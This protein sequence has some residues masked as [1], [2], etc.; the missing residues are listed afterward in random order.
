MREVSKTTR[1][2]VREKTLYIMRLLGESFFHTRFHDQPTSTAEIGSSYFPSRQ[3]RKH[4]GGPHSD[5]KTGF[6][7]YQKYLTPFWTFQRMNEGYSR[8][9]RKTKH[10]KLKAEVERELEQIWKLPERVPVVD[11]NTGLPIVPADLPSNGVA[12]TS[13]SKIWIQPLIEF[14]VRPLD[15]KICR[16]EGEIPKAI[17]FQ[18]PALAA[19][20]RALYLAKKWV[21]S[22]GGLPNLYSDYKEDEPS[23]GHG[24]LWGIGPLHPQFMRRRVRAVLFGG[25]GLWDYD[26][27]A[28]HYSIIRSLARHYGQPSPLLDQYLEGREA[29]HARLG[30]LLEV[31]PRRLKEVFNALGYGAK[32]TKHPSTAIFQIVG[33]NGIDALKRDTFV[34]AFLAE[35]ARLVDVVFE[36]EVASKAEVI[37]VVGKAMEVPAKRSGNFGGQMLSHILQGWESYCLDVVCRGFRDTTCLIFDGWV[38]PRRR[39]VAYLENQLRSESKREH[40]IEM[41]LRMKEELLE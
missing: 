22:F 25:L 1:Q 3:L 15:E 14:D 20:V 19:R 33:A 17:V 24:R 35:H 10:Y 16:L 13:Y 31:P 23:E 34:Q 8:A 9:G 27:V 30:E 36:H 40:G 7:E 12:R 32:L 39:S 37:N 5:P 41:A 26:F 21:V 38:S 28:C 2:K 18:R 4:L 6:S 11:R 29:Q